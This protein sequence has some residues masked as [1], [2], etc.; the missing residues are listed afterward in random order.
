MEETD[1]YYVT[2]DTRG[3][4]EWARDHHL[5][6]SVGNF[7]AALGHDKY[8][9]RDQLLYERKHG[10]C[11]VINRHTI[12][13]VTN[14]P[15]AL[16]WLADTYNIKVT[17]SNFIIPK[18]NMY[19]GGS[20][21]GFVND[22]CGVEVKCP[23]RMPLSLIQHKKDLDNGKTFD[24]YYHDHITTTHYDQM[25]GYMKITNRKKWL[26]LVY[27]K[28]QRRVHLETVLFNE[29]YW[30][31]VLYPGILEFLEMLKKN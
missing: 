20:I 26:Y 22:D 31:N 23:E 19:I 3:G 16:K 17:R 14:E 2:E 15:E 4:K 12:R 7:G 28:D 24:P 8:K 1:H 27:V 5:K 6:L 21:D 18:F 9:T 25:Q 29:G 10:A 13:G 11:K 30:E